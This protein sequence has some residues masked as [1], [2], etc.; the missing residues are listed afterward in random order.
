MVPS[1]NTIAAAGNGESWFHYGEEAR[2]KRLLHL[3]KAAGVHIGDLVKGF[4]LMNRH[5][6]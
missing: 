2:V 3:R 1:W 4:I 5:M 6:I